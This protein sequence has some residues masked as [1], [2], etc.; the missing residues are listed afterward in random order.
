MQRCADRSAG[1]RPSGPWRG[2][3]MAPKKEKGKRVDA[4][5]VDAPRVDLDDLDEPAAGDG[6]VDTPLAQMCAKCGTAE[7]KNRSQETPSDG[8]EHCLW[9]GT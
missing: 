6:G 3:G 1:P 9:R 5:R 4:P 2:A 7:A 8:G